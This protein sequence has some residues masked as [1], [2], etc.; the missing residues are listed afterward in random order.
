MKHK[1]IS[2]I[3][4]RSYKIQPLEVH[5]EETEKLLEDVK[6]S[7]S[8]FRNYNGR[9]RLFKIVGILFL[10]VTF[11]LTGKKERKKERK[12]QRTN[13]TRGSFFSFC[14]WWKSL[15]MLVRRNCT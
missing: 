14:C 6:G 2:D 7:P 8:V 13:E 10:V 12:K 5:K 3:E 15:G 11:V 9:R 4:N 1:E